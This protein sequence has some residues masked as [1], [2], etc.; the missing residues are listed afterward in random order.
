MVGAAAPRWAAEGEAEP[1]AGAGNCW[2]PR[3]RGWDHTTKIRT[4]QLFSLQSEGML[5]FKVLDLV[6]VYSA[7]S[8]LYIGKEQSFS[9]NPTSFFIISSVGKGNLYK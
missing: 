4:E 7:S 9:N 5:H 6:K 3:A 1:A 8:Q 2:W